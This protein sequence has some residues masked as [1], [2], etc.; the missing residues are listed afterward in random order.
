MSEQKQIWL[1]DDDPIAVTIMRHVVMQH[2]YFELSKEFSG[3]ENLLSEVKVED[4]HIPDLVILD[5]NMPLMSGWELLE[6]LRQDEKCRDLPVAIFT[7]SI[8]KQDAKKS[9]RYSNV[10]GHFVK[11]ITRSL[12]EDIKSRLIQHQESK[13]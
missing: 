11:P 7:S 6:F 9:E 8:D 2:P 4:C 5:L 12:L 1:V 10:I 13:R 3:A